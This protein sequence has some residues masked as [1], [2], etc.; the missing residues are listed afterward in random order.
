MR[1]LDRSKD[2][3]VKKLQ[4][5]DLEAKVKKKRKALAKYQKG[6]SEGALV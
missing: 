2:K 5:R 1:A 6:M 4:R 3:V